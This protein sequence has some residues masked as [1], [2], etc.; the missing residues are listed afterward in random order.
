MFLPNVLELLAS[1]NT[2]DIVAIPINNHN[3]TNIAVEIMKWDETDMLYIVTAV[4]GY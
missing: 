3:C 2:V 4:Q 1:T